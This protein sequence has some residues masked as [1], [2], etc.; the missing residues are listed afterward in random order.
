ME[1]KIVI[2]DVTYTIEEASELYEELKKI[3]DKGY[4]SIRT[5]RVGEVKESV[6]TR[7]GIIKQENTKDIKI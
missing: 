3:F 7:G 4:I 1:V 5:C 2:C 6:L